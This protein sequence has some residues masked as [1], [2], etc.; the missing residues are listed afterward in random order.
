MFIAV[1]AKV[2]VMQQL[3]LG[4]ATPDVAAGGAREV[5]A[6]GARDINA[7]GARDVTAGGAPGRLAL[8]TTLGPI[9]VHLALALVLGAAL[10]AGAAALLTQAAE[11][12][13]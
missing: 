4:N 9:W 11:L 6:G 2:N 12:L 13:R 1:A 5:A 10:P 8:L 7:G 3:C